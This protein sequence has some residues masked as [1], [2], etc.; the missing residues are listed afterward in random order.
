MSLNPWGLKEK[1]TFPREVC[2]GSNM[3]GSGGVALVEEVCHCGYGL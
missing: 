1:S 2:D 3:L